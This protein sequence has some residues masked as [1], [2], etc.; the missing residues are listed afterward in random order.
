LGTDSREPNEN[1]V[2]VLYRIAVT[3]IVITVAS[4]ALSSF[5]ESPSAAGAFTVEAIG[6]AGEGSRLWQCHD[7]FKSRG[8]PMGIMPV[9]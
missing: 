8:R 5:D 9:G 7:R 3:A 6:Q 2:A 1:E 4:T